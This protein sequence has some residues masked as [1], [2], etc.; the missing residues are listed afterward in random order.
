MR[1]PPNTE[2]EKNIY[3]DSPVC[4]LPFRHSDTCNIYHTSPKFFERVELDY[5][6]VLL[7]FNPCAWPVMP[8]EKGDAKNRCAT[9]QACN[10][11]IAAWT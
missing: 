6:L 4:V 7:G 11:P 8:L 5:G 1:F 3:T 2:K 9:T 10:Q